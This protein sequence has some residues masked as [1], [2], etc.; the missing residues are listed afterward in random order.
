MAISWLTVLR[1]VPWTDV[2]SNAPKVA[3]GARKL[4]SSVSGKREQPAYREEARTESRISDSAALSVLR[5]EVADLEAQVDEL[6]G[7]M[8]ASSGLIKDLADQNA[9]LIAR[10]ELMRRRQA[11]IA[12]AAA[13]AVVVS[14]AAAAI[15]LLPA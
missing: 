3:D 13:V 10:V 2:I 1:N 7:Q 11:W 9:Q 6:R 5:E 8:L 4:W 12:G 15:A 14:V